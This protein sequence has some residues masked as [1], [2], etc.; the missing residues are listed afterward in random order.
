MAAS[1]VSAGDRPC[2]P[3]EAWR[4]LTT[5]WLIR[6][7]EPATGSHVQLFR[8]GVTGDFE[9]RLQRA[10]RALLA[11]DFLLRSL[12]THLALSSPAAFQAL[13]SGF[14]H[15]KLYRTAGEAGELTR[16]LAEQL[17][18]MVDEIGASVSR[19]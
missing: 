1:G 12:L 7:L 9:T 14:T 19:N 6:G 4:P 17:Q 5:N 16:E 18:R 13:V 8:A 2:G 10:E 15:S 11:Q 3:T